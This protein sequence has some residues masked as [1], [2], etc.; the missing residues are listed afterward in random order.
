MCYIDTCILHLI[1]ACIY[2]NTHTIQE[3]EPGFK[4]APS[5]FFSTLS[6]GN[7]SYASVWQGRDESTNLQQRHDTELIKEQKRYSMQ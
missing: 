2:T 3:E 1:H 7:Q 6:E 4:M 5:K